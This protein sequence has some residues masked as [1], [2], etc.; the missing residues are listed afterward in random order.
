VEL[1]EFPAFPSFLEISA[2]EINPEDSFTNPSAP[3]L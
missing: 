1:S 3:D 2:P